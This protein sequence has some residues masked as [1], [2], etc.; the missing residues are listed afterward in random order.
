M[1][2]SL[3]SPPSNLQLQSPLFGVLPGEIRNQ[4]FTFAL[5]QHGDEAATYPRDSYWYRPGFS[6]PQHSNSALLRT[7][8]MAY[9]EGQKVFL[10]ELEWAFWF[11][12]WYCAFVCGTV[13]LTSSRSWSR[14]SYRK[15]RMHGILSQPFYAS[16]PIASEIPLL[17]TDVLARGWQQL[18]HALCAASIP[19]HASHYHN[20]ILRLVALG[21]R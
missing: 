3:A 13:L 20:S 11:G 8:R 6:G 2:F 4:V 1:V 7:C 10:R 17:H 19:P 16:R 18:A 21:K 12:T 14:G 5:M 15:S 9:A